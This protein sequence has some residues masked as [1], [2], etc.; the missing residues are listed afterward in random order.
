MIELFDDTYE[1]YLIMSNFNIERNDTSLKAFLNNS[2]LYN[3]IKSNTCFKGKD[4]CIDNI[5]LRLAAHMT[6]ILVIIIIT[7]DLHNVKIL[8]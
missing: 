1:N 3:L 7:Y 2:N 5:Q 4:S 6:Q 8:F